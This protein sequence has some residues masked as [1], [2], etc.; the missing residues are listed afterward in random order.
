MSFNAI[1]KV[2][3]GVVI[4]GIF[5]A[6]SL[7]SLLQIAAPRLA[8]TKYGPEE[9]I[10]YKPGDVVRL[11]EREVQVLGY[12]GMSEETANHYRTTD[13]SEVWV[14]RSLQEAQQ[15]A[16]T[17]TGN[18]T[19][20]TP[21]VVVVVQEIGAP[22]PPEGPQRF[23]GPHNPI[24]PRE[25][26]RVSVLDQRQQVNEKTDVRWQAC[27]QRWWTSVVDIQPESEEMAQEVGGS[28][29]DSEEETIK[30]CINELQKAAASKEEVVAKEEPYVVEPDERFPPW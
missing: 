8:K 17:N 5:S 26:H 13:G 21:V 1:G 18:G 7:D 3:S 30:T 19:R 12:S 15:Y 29:W 9:Q 20:G 6:L 24:L 11:Q 16:L 14:T 4:G 23:E 2:L 25:E 27:L 28:C 10:P 22:S